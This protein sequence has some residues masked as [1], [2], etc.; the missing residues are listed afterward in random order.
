MVS[1]Q[2]AEASPTMR[3]LL[4]TANMLV[5]NHGIDVMAEETLME[6]LE[7]QETVEEAEGE[8]TITGRKMENVHTLISVWQS[9]KEIDKEMGEAEVLV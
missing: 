9:L 7:I 2:R 4:D 6:A 1:E 8:A 3:T 5:H